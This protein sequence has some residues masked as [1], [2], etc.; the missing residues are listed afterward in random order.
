MQDN[1]FDILNDVHVIK[2]MINKAMKKSLP[3]GAAVI[4]PVNVYKDGGYIPEVPPSLTVVLS[5]ETTVAV[6]AR[7]EL[8]LGAIT[9]DAQDY[10]VNA[11]SII[12][13]GTRV[14]NLTPY[15]VSKSCYVD[16]WYKDGS[17]N[18]KV[19]IVH[20]STVNVRVVAWT[21]KES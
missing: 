17:D 9:D 20:E 12:Y 8:D 5:T 7:V 13:G 21:L 10:V 2:A 15:P 4:S 19:V 1:R 3:R 16:Y 6:N 14:R 11:F 18:L